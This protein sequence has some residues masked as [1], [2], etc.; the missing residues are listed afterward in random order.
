LTFANVTATIAL[1]FAM[2]GGAL[3]AR[4]YL[5]TSTSQIKPSVLRALKGEA[6]QAGGDGVGV[7][8]RQ[9]TGSAGSCSAG[10]TEFKAANGTTFACNGKDGKEPP[11]EK[12][13]KEPPTWP[14]TLPSGRTETG[15]WGF[16]SHAEGSVRVPIS[17][18]VPT[19]GLLQPTLGVGP[20]EFLEPEEEDPI[21]AHPNCLG[22]VDEPKAKPGFLCVYA[23]TLEVPLTGNG[24]VRSSGIVLI[25][26]AASAAA[27]VDEG[28]WAMTAP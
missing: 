25:F 10:G 2:S 22:A 6:G 16:A 15:T 1:L 24:P 4:H 11:W 19:N 13:P 21:D 5:I 3:A 14:S 27:K 18:P 8:S 12:P 7:T 17:F 26:D 28:T 23:E 20:V 9:F